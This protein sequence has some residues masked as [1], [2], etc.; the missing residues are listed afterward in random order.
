ME[1]VAGVCD[2]MLVV[3]DY[4]EEATVDHHFAAVVIDKAKLPELIH[5]V[6]DP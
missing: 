2:M 1:P 4:A 3:L 6:T 5:E